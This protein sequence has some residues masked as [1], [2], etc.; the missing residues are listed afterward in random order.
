MSIIS[1]SRGSYSKGKEVAEGV[2]E[3]LGYYVSP[4]PLEFSASESFSRADQIAF[5]KAGIRCKLS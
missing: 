2:A 5:A 3:E 1:I 4:V